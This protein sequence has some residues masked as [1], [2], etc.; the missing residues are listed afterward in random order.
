M[1]QIKLVLLALFVL[2]VLLVL[3][4]FL[5]TAGAG[6]VPGSESKVHERAPVRKN[7]RFGGRPLRRIRAALT[8][9]HLLFFLLSMLLWCEWG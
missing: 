4:V 7:T 8:R 6:V 5:T 9:G 2:S 3:L 1:T